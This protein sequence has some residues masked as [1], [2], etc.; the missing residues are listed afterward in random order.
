MFRQA[1]PIFRKNLKPMAIIT[2]IAFLP[3][4]LLQFFIPQGFA[5]S[6]MG[7]VEANIYYLQGLMSMAELDSATTPMASG[8][9]LYI[10]MTIGVELVFFPISTA[11]ATYMVDCSLSGKD[12]EPDG[13]FSAALSRFPKMLVTTAIVA[14]SVYLFIIFF[15]GIFVF[16][17]V[18]F[19]ITM[20]F[21]QNIVSDTGKWGLNGIHMSRFMVRGRFFQVFLRCILFFGLYFFSLF[22]LDTFGTVIGINQM[23][24]VIQLF[25]FILKKFLLSFYAV[26]FAC[27][28]FDIKKRNMEIFKAIENMVNK[29]AEEFKDKIE[30]EEQQDEDTKK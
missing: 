29:M 10:I 13:I 24:V 17:G 12:T 7:Y 19:G 9:Y 30:Q 18:Y 4:F 3:V 8:A 11:A 14:A 1:M 21:Y 27:W 23:N 5:A 22:A 25:Y 16:F 20:I 28:Y 26:A 2:L 6:F 15:G